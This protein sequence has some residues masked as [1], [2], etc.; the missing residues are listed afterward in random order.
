VRIKNRVIPD[1]QKNSERRLKKTEG[2]FSRPVTSF[3]GLKNAQRRTGPRKQKGG[4]KQNGLGVE[5]GMPWA[6]FTTVAQRIVARLR[7]FMQ[8]Y[9]L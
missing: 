8:G 1:A 5:E 9:D 6:R 2:H 7:T 4:K 3:R